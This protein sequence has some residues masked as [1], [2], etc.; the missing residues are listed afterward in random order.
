MVC[1]FQVR[2]SH[3]WPQQ[4]PAAYLAKLGRP[5]RYAGRYVEGAEVEGKHDDTNNQAL[6]CPLPYRFV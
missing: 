2:L 1:S 3:A 6:G 4:T 5:G